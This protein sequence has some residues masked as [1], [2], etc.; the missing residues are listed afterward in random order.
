MKTFFWIALCSLILASSIFIGRSIYIMG[1]ED[2]L[3]Q[4]INKQI[5]GWDLSEDAKGGFVFKPIVK[6]EN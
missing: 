6:E 1:I 4:G 3:K 2:G 5:I